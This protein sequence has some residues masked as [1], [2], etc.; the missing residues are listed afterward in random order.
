MNKSASR[1]LR[2]AKIASVAVSVAFLATACAPI[3]PVP[4]QVKWDG[5]YINVP[6]GDGV[7]VIDPGT[8]AIDYS[9]PLDGTRSWSAPSDTE[10]GE[11]TAPVIE[12]GVATWGFKGSD[13]TV[14][15]NEQ[16]GRLGVTLDSPSDRSVAWPVS[17]VDSATRS[18]EFPNGEGQSI[19]VDDP[20]WLSEA[21][22]LD[23]SSWDVAG[24]LTL[25][26]WGTSFEGSGV[27]Y[28]V[29][30]DIATTLNFRAPADR[31][32][33]AAEH[34]FSAGRGTSSYE[35]TLAPTDGN[36]VAAAQDYRAWLESE[37]ALVTLTDKIAAN[38]NVAKLSGALHAY[39]WDDGRD[40][41]I[42][43][44]L[45]KLGIENA[46]LGSD[47]TPLSAEAVTAAKAAGY[48]VGP[49]DTWANA[50]DP[51]ASDTPLAEWPDPLWPNGCI[52]DEA[53]E[54]VG[55][56]GGRG[57][58]LSSSALDAAEKTDGAISDRVASLTENGSD[59][60]FLDVDAV[61]Q[62]F[63]DFSPEH[64]QTEAEDRAKRLAR[65]TA[66]A[67]GEYSNGSPLVLG[68][69][70]VAAWA[71]SAVS[72]SHGSSTP[73]HNGIWP[74]QK[75]RAEWGAYWPEERPGFFFKP[76]ELPSE[77]ATAMFD[78]RYRVP[79][80]ESV[81]HDSV[82]STDRWEMGLYKFEGLETDR[83]LTNLLYNTPAVVA[84]DEQMLE[85]HGMQLAQMQK[86]F[87][88]LQDAAGTAPMTSF[89]RIG[90]H[91]Q[92]TVFGD[93]ALT[94]TANFGEG[95]SAGVGEK[96]VRIDVPGVQSL[97]YCP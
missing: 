77:L 87:G 47:G 14:T 93:N 42:V 55:G 34:T 22:E 75:D 43:A 57:C 67:A 83:I 97:D 68:S 60:Y 80:Y 65:M 4:S 50:Q 5:T 1:P 81:L 46:W 70:T 24:S 53:G 31:L 51:S 33:A 84:L 89:E 38:P 95:K 86:V 44:Q 26:F 37:G 18:I 74:F 10:L 91:V 48:L 39:I 7:A 79:L 28:T 49:Y 2:R 45:Q 73:L 66:L 21:A 82:G 40:T 96:C 56:F 64:P 12:E 25:P 52:I 92:R 9:S 94:V 41:Q 54:P 35:V 16:N 71:N 8:L 19:P 85:Q 61:G 15:L 72:Y 13:L 3:P 58:Y 69:E 59:S 32:Q 23:G 90:E 17:A 11:P 88:I 6:V 63:Q 78:P 62:L 29:H 76:I 30:T 27:S 36:P 20:F